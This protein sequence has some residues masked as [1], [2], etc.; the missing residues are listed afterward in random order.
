MFKVNPYFFLKRLSKRLIVRAYIS[1]VV[2]LGLALIAVWFGPFVPDEWPSILGS[3]SVDEILK[4]IASSMLLVT[5]FSLSTMVAAYSTASD[6]VTP[7]AARLL[8]EDRDSHNALSIF[9]GAFIFSIVSIIALSTE[10]YGEK[11]RFILFI[12]TVI[13]LII[14]VLTI[15]S[16]IE[17]LSKLGRVHETVKVIEE[18]TCQALKKL[19]HDPL[20][21]ARCYESEVP[22]AIEV[23]HCEIGYIQS[24]NYSGLQ[25]IANKNKIEIFIELAPGAYV[26]PER[27]IAKVK[28]GQNATFTEA[29]AAALRSCFDIGSC[30]LYDEDPRFGLIT[31]AEVASRALSPAVND[32]GTA[33]DVISSMVRLLNCWD[34]FTKGLR[35]EVSF[36][37][38]YVRSFDPTVFFDDIVR[39]LSR[40]GAAHIEVMI[41]LSKALKSFEGFRDPA[42]CDQAKVHQK[43]LLERALI[44]LKFED[45]RKLLQK[46]TSP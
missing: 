32:P 18:T 40:D 46:L 17:K 8:M 10:Y 37:R 2:A 31:L 28:L 42:L 4:I 21:G 25:D 30:R 22:D 26:F 7:R 12:F 15:V 6:G 36:D 1:V 14:I 44:S 16:W 13:L 38:L 23:S 9:L 3:R 39:P 29:T 41:R 27:L 5:T 43:H 45:D 34:E 33:I 24:I 35:S 19:G 11:G 20:R